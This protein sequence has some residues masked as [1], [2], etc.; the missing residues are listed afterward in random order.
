MEFNVNSDS[1]THPEVS[2]NKAS[3]TKSN[4]EIESVKQRIANLE[5][6]ISYSSSPQ[7]ITETHHVSVQNLIAQYESKSQ[8]LSQTTDK[9]IK[10]PQKPFESKHE[11][12]DN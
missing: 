1:Y 2:E 4:P 8:N 12:T 6:S 11:K 5:K 3:Q 10:L 9:I 7:K